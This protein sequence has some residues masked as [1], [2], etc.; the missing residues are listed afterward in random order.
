MRDVCLYISHSLTSL[1][2]LLWDRFFFL[3]KIETDAMNT[4]FKS[5]SKKY[6]LKLY[7][8]RILNCKKCGLCGNL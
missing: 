3:H 2:L 7:M 5:R 6:E 1:I 8:I 4:Y